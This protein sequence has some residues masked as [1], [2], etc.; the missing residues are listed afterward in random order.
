[1]PCPR[2]SARHVRPLL[3]LLAAAGA[4]AAVAAG[5]PRPA[6]PERDDDGAVL[7]EAASFEIEVDVGSGPKPYTVDGVI[8]RPAALS[9][10]NRAPA[11]LLIHGSNDGSRL[12]KDL[13]VTIAGA[14]TA[15]GK[16]AK[17]FRAIA[18][19]LVRE[20]FVVYRHHKRGYA[21]DRNDDRLDVVRTI[22]LA[23]STGDSRRALARLRE[24][25]WVDPRRIVLLGYSE[26]T[27]LAP[28]I[29]K[30][31]DGVLGVVLIG[32]VVDFDRVARFQTVDK[33][34]ADAFAAFDRDDD[35]RIDAREQI[36]PGP[37]GSPRPAWI[38]A[39]GRL[40]RDRDGAISRS[41]ADVHL[42]ATAFRPF[43][44]GSADPESYWHGHFRVPTNLE[45]LP[46]FRKPVI[47]I[48]GEED[49]RTPAP[50]ARELEA[51]MKAAGH[52]SMTF[53]YYPGLGHGLSPPRPAPEGGVF[54]EE[55]AGPP[56]AEVLAE[57]AA[58]ARERFGR[59][60]DGPF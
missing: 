27:M 44:D 58:L 29:A 32:C 50:H 12:R 5:T 19:A 24:S 22:T 11:V 35:G 60:R 57:M 43:K 51:R 53:R 56:S 31:D 42:A 10:G 48:Q 38:R 2:L 15:D 20:G 28:V 30:D 6:T 49:W 41:E 36:A 18:H 39:T 55:T 45:A 7:E 16:E 8:A 3:L 25:P 21:T 17:R 14:R 40:D 37:P 23:R 9:P 52:P 46:A 13:D 59:E 54:R 33:P 47:L 1:M 34:I 26:G 4:L